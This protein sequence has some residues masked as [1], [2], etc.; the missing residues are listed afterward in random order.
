MNL[1][2]WLEGANPTLRPRM[3]LDTPAMWLC[4]DLCSG[5]AKTCSASTTQVM[6]SSRMRSRIPESMKVTAMPAGSA[7]PL[8]SSTTYS[9][10]SGRSSTRATAS[11]RSL[12]IEQQTQP[13]ARLM[14]SLL[15][16]TTSSASMLIEPKSFTSTAT[17]KP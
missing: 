1:P 17:R 13:L 9:G 4:S 8:A 16:S 14:T 15:C 5:A 6:L 11:S 10:R 2:P 3:R 12:R 7:T